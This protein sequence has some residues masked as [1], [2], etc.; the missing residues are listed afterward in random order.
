MGSKEALKFIFVI[1]DE[2]SKD[3]AKKIAKD[4]G[5]YERKKLKN[6]KL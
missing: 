6:F 4:G 1:F 3:K 5:K 2:V